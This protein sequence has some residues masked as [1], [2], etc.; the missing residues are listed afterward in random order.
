MHRVIG[1]PHAAAGGADPEPACGPSARTSARSPAPRR[2]RRS[3]PNRL[4]PLRWCSAGRSSSHAAPSA[5]VARDRPRRE[6]P[7]TSP[8]AR[9]RLRAIRA[10][11]ETP[12][13]RRAGRR[14]RAARTC[15]A[16]RPRSPDPA[17]GRSPSWRPPR[18]GWQR[19][20]VRA[21]LHEAEGITSRG[22][23]SG[24]SA[25]LRTVRRRRSR[26]SS[27]NP[28]STHRSLPSVPNE[29]LVSAIS[30]AGSA[31][32]FTSRLRPGPTRIR[33]MRTCAFSNC[34]RSMCVSGD[35]SR[36]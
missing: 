27:R 11:R 9:A 4:R 13:R 35:A 28:G 30:N 7:S 33:V 18:R 22:A 24:R 3:F 14:S 25:A 36:K 12:A 19:W 21:G 5:C 26:A 10:G 16:S 34:T 1:A 29:V 31:A 23:S 15:P 32:V 17:A 2:G 20:S 6:R 8:R